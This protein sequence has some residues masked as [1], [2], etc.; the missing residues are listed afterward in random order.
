MA[1]SD[2]LQP[3][4]FHGTA[5]WFK[6]GDVIAPGQRDVYYDVVDITHNAP[7][8]MQIGAYATTRLNRARTYASSAMSR[9][10]HGE[11]NMQDHAQRALF[12]PVYEVEHVSENSDP[13]EQLPDKY[14]R[15][16][17]GFRVKGN[18]VAY[19]YYNE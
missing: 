2:N 8:H 15:D 16:L 19:S 10:E 14:H 6:S 1:A 9:K 5:H 17:Q 18:P 7:E 4:L 11:M 12:S 3:R 13:L